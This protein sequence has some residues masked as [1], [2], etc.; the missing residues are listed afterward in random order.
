MSSASRGSSG[1]AVG[2][3]P[4]SAGALS[5]RLRSVGMRSG[6]EFPVVPFLGI[7]LVVRVLTDGTASPDSRHSGSLGLAGVIAVAFAA[8]ALALL[9]RR[10][11]GLAATALAALWLSI[12]TVVA[13]TTHG[14]STETLR[15]GV[16]E[17]SVVALGVIVYNARGL[18]TVG[19]AA[20]LVQVVGVVPAIVAIHQLLTHTG[21]DLAGT[22][23]AN[24]TFAHPDSA[25]MY[26]AIAAA[27]SAWCYLDDGRHRLD[28]VLTALFST[29]LVATLSIDGL[30]TLAAMLVALAVLRQDTLREKV[31]LC[32]LA[33]LVVVAFVATPLGAKRLVR[34]S[35][36]NVA[37]A[38]R[39]EPNTSL[40]W[41]LHKWKT[42]LPQWESS[43]LLG[44]GLGTTSTGEGAPG[45]RYAFKP[46]HNEYVRYLVETGVLGFLVLLAALALLVRAL[47]RM[48]RLGGERS[49]GTRN[50]A[51]FALVIVFGCLVNSLA[52]NTFLNSP[53]CYAA[54]LIVIA[55]LCLPGTGARRLQ[56]R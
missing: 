23:R 51:S 37:S 3:L 47:A 5:A 55:A 26:F 14:A 35:T 10:R 40:A 22:I 54:A 12:W 19:T 44:Q 9:V 34:E 41:R 24:G 13:V 6:F 38:E 45:D 8:A 31:G 27:A 46:P 15:E 39:N 16:R 52:D 20:R 2:A 7:A 50:A 11:Q 48:R 56:L 30:A 28:A 43:P 49:E 29:A 33:G 25:A 4:A 53:T 1:S 36:T 17:G 21:V 32:L 18:V 42:L